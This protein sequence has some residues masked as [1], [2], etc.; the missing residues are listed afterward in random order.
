MYSVFVFFFNCIASIVRLL[1]RFV[2]WEGFTY[3]DFCYAL[4]LIPVLFKVISIIKVNLSLT[5]SEEEVDE[6]EGKHAMKYGGYKPKHAPY[7]GKHAK[8]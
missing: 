6:Y 3:L 7:E 2:L 1:D 8:R 4:I 5:L